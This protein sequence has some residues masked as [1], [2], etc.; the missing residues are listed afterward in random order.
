MEDWHATNATLPV[1]SRNNISINSSRNDQ[2]T[3]ITPIRQ[4]NSVTTQISSSSTTTS[5]MASDKWQLPRRGRLKCNVDA[6][7]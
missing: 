6:S 2:T 4:V 7:F 3:T 1:A 5:D